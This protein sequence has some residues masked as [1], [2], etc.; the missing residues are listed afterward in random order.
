MCNASPA[1]DSVPALIAS[2]AVAK[3]AGPNGF[4]EV[5][6]DK[7]HAGPGKTTLS[8]KEFIVTIKIPRPPAR[9]A[10]AYLRFIPRTEMDIAVVGVGAAVTLDNDGNCTSVRLA[11]G[12]VAPTARLVKTVA[13]ILIGHKLNEKTLGQLGTT[14]RASCDPIDDKRGT[15]EFRTH[16]AGVLAARTIKIAWQRAEAR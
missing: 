7:I 4:R 8:S 9:S 3:V 11:L 10:D 15:I 6:V 1:A 2:S 16:V 5:P 12:A 13:P 14:V